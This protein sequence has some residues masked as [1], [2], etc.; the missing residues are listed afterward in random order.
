MRYH[1]RTLLIVVTC[2]AVILGWFTWLKRKADFHRREFARRLG[3]T[4]EDIE[5]TLDHCIFD[6][7]FD[8]NGE[9]TIPV[10]RATPEVAN[11][12]RAAIRHYRAAQ[13]FESAALRP[14]ALLSRDTVR[15]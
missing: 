8:R 14:W 1:V 3:G 10:G 15:H 7:A 12:W 6:P 9:P 11:Y 4:R 13:K 5:W 2:I